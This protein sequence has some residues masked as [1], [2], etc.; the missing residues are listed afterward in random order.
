MA[1]APLLKYL[2]Q[3][4]P[5]LGAAPSRRMAKALRQVEEWLH[6]VKESVVEVH[7]W[8]DGN[9]RPVRVHPDMTVPVPELQY[10]FYA[11]KEELNGVIDSLSSPWPF[12]KKSQREYGRDLLEEL[13]DIAPKRSYD[14]FE[15]LL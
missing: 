13:K 14:E 8:L 15:S 4:P 3:L 5:D 7:F 12:G 6:D 9:S 1:L 11:L 10:E 2:Q